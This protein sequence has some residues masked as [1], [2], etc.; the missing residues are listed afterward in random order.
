ML[1]DTVLDATG[2]FVEQP[3]ALGRAAAWVCAIAGA[4]VCIVVGAARAVVATG[5]D[6]MAATAI[7]V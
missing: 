1:T 5:R 3:S 2:D 7:Y 6:G 4:P